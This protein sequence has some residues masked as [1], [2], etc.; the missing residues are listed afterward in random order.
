MKKIL[1]LLIVVLMLVSPTAA[2]ADAQEICW[3]YYRFPFPEGFTAEN[4]DISPVLIYS[5][6]EM[7]LLYW[8][9]FS[10]LNYGSSGNEPVEGYDALKTLVESMYYQYS[11]KPYLSGS[12][13]EAS[14][15]IDT[16]SAMQDGSMMTG[17]LFSILKKNMLLQGLVSSGNIQSDREL[18]KKCIDNIQVGS[19]L[20]TQKQKELTWSI[21]SYDEG[22]TVLFEAGD[23]QYSVDIPDRFEIYMP[24]MG[25]SSPLPAFLQM[26][27]EEMEEYIAGL[28]SQIQ[29]YVFAVDMSTFTVLDIAVDDLTKFN[30]I[31]TDRYGNLTQES[32]DTYLK[33]LAES[34]GEYET[35]THY[36]RDYYIFP[37]YQEGYKIRTLMGTDDV[38]VLCYNPIN[39]VSEAIKISAFSA[40]ASVNRNN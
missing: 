27:V 29:C 4:I 30:Y 19:G 16:I 11:L 2:F 10:S 36:G 28:R 8:F 3:G 15:R 26:T 13:N 24:G 14:W 6:N 22:N 12:K 17:A 37:D 20:L 9:D 5:D 34:Q 1:M 18:A 33:G 35:M 25:S 31:Q 7:I 38:S 32:I 39:A 23:K 21:S 40:L